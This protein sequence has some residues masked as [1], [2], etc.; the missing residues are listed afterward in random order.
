MPA[1]H[2]GAD[3]GLRTAAVAEADDV[4]RQLAAGGARPPWRVVPPAPARSAAQMSSS[5]AKTACVRLM[6]QAPQGFGIIVCPYLPFRIETSF[7][8]T[9]ASVAVVSAKGAPRAD[10]TGMWRRLRTGTAGQTEPEQQ[11]RISLISFSSPSQPSL[12]SSTDFQSGN[13]VRVCGA[14]GPGRFCRAERESWIAKDLAGP[15]WYAE[16]RPGMSLLLERPP[17]RVFVMRKPE[18][19]VSRLLAELGRQINT[20]LLAAPTG[21]NGAIAL[22]ATAPSTAAGVS[23]SLSQLLPARVRDE[24][25]DRFG[26]VL[27]DAPNAADLLPPAKVADVTLQRLCAAGVACCLRERGWAC[28][29]EPFRFCPDEY[30]WGD[31]AT[32]PGRRGSDGSAPAARATGQAPSVDVACRSAYTEAFDTRLIADLELTPCV[33]KTFPLEPRLRAAPETGPFVPEQPSGL[34]PARPRVCVLPQGTEAEM[35]HLWPRLPQD[36][37]RLPP[38]LRSAKAFAAYWR[39]VHGYVLPLELL[40]RSAFARVEFPR[41][42][43][44]LTYPV[45]CLWLETWTEMP[46]LTRKLAPSIVELTVE[47]LRE[48]R[49]FLLGASQSLTFA[50]A[51]DLPLAPATPAAA[52]ARGPPPAAAA[53]PRFPATRAVGVLA[54]V[55]A[56]GEPDTAA[57]GVPQQQQQQQHLLAP[58]PATRALQ[59]RATAS[60]EGVSLG[61]GAIDGDA[62][63]DADAAGDE[64]A[65]IL[66]PPPS[67]K[68]RR[69]L[70]QVAISAQASK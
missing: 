62:V 53:A 55:A 33:R 8:V 9:I 14:Q 70:H 48:S 5:K 29:G 7:H 44:A 40:E 51:L 41:A 47:T 24:L 57:R 59:A 25:E 67:R 37:S 4:A 30:L 46:S 6:L 50:P 35:T 39:F 34:L 60:A 69:T 66:V 45:A 27:A 31:A 56:A 13:S 22:L 64:S 23:A 38:E 18:A 2:V 58:V 49:G 52:R 10:I 32:V 63:D 65:Q 43:F 1:A 17:E 11:V 26:V 68:R 28:I 15:Q 12:G 20:S 61:D 54:A 42:G 36:R 3:W 16:L 19:Q 21:S